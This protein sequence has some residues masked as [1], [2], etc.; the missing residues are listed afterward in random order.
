M[1]LGV[2]WVFNPQLSP[3]TSN[4][5]CA[6]F[7]RISERSEKIWIVLALVL[8]LLNIEFY[9]GNFS[10]YGTF[11]PDCHDLF[12]AEVCAEHAQEKEATYH[13]FYSREK[14]EAGEHPRMNIVA[15][16]NFWVA[17]MI[18]TSIGIKCQHKI[19]F[20]PLRYL[21]AL[22]VFVICVIGTVNWRR[23]TKIDLFLSCLVMGFLLFCFYYGHWT[24]YQ[25]TFVE[26]NGI[27]G[28]Y[29]Y[30]VLAPLV[31]LLVKFIGFALPLKEHYRL[32]PALFCT[33]FGLQVG[34]FI[35]PFFAGLVTPPDTEF[36]RIL[37][38]YP[39]PVYDRNFVIVENKLDAPGAY[40]LQ[41]PTP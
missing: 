12:N 24:S 2:L 18:D 6:T 29:S 38:Y 4:G 1:A 37:G 25:E 40:K 36:Y 20:G 5:Q 19:T 28:R 17:E 9:L 41:Y 31:A 8:A 39:N 23:L 3:T 34:I 27:N 32:A 16:F 7:R 33:F 14:V 22:V 10:Q 30:L 21:L 35:S 13:S 11:L 15:Y 26:L